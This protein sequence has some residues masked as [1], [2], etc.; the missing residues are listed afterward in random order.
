MLR[1]RIACPCDFKGIF[2]RSS[3]PS[4]YENKEAHNSIQRW[5]KISRKMSGINASNQSMKKFH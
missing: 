1:R 4:L 5:N 3:E 2:L